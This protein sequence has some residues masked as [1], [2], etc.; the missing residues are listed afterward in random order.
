MVMGQQRVSCSSYLEVVCEVEDPLG[1]QELADDMRG[2]QFA[3]RLD[4]LLD[5]GIVASLSV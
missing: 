4:I 5:C 3:N 2:L 1:V